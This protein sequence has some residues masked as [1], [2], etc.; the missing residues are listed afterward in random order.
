MAIRAFVRLSWHF[1]TT[2]VSWY[3]AKTAIAREAVR[4]YRSQPLYKTPGPALLLVGLSPFKRLNRLISSYRAVDAVAGTP[5]SPCASGRSVPPPSATAP[6]SPPRRS[7]PGSEPGSRSSRVK[8]SRTCDTVTA[9]VFPPDPPPLAAQEPQRQQRQR[10]VVVPPHPAPDLVLG[11]PV[12]AACPPRTPPRS[13]AC[14]N[15]TRTNS[16]NA[17]SGPALLRA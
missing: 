8:T 17:T 10:H 9:G 6:A 13:G 16:S 14:V 5:R 1:Y 12:F 7:A 2:S 3:E 11:Q 15:R 4:T